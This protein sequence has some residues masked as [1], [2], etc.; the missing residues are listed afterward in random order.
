M[1]YLLNTIKHSFTFQSSDKYYVICQ[2]FSDYMV[3]FEFSENY[4]EGVYYNKL[5]LKD[6][7]ETNENCIK[8]MG[9]LLDIV[10]KFVLSI[11]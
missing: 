7:E 5:H 8:V 1:S 3:I 6:F 11:N 2:S 9:R 10:F 4:F